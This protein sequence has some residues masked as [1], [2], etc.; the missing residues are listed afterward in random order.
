VMMQSQCLPTSQIRRLR[1]RRKI[2][3]P[4]RM[5]PKR[6]SRIISRC[7]LLA[8][9]V[10]S[11]VNEVTGTLP[12]YTSRSHHGG[13]QI[14]TTPQTGCRPL[15]DQICMSQTPI[16]RTNIVSLRPTITRSQKTLCATVKRIGILRVS[17]LSRRLPT[18]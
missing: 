14:D 18:L 3:Q 4:Q 1:A 16:L 12:T 15:N 9:K 8:R 11:A 6:T 13:T 5:G 7:Q 17:A 2:S 10:T